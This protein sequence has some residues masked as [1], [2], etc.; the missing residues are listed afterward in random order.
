MKSTWVAAAMIAAGLLSGC[1]DSDTTDASASAVSSTPLKAEGGYIVGKVL[2]QDGK[3]IAVA[4]DI[5]L[6]VYGVSEAG[7]KVSYSPGVKPDGTYKQ[8]LV[9]G[10]YRMGRAIVK[11]KFGE[12]LFNFELT[13]KGNLYNKD[14]D[15]KDGIEQDYVWNMTGQHTTDQPDP[16]NHTHWYG[17]NIGMRFS[18]WRNDINKAPTVPPDGTKLIFTLKPLTKLVNGEDGK[19]LTIEREWQSKAYPQ[20]ADLNDLPPASYEVTGVAKLPDGS[21]KTILLLGK[22]DYPK[23]VPVTKATLELD[24]ILGGMAKPPIGWVVE[25]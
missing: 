13:P 10:S 22:G 16:N 7:E 19:E 9:A 1:G 11:V 12:H 8:K 17:M 14:R 6:S 5:A 18:G 4:E 23:F 24:G 20:S 2:G 25:E 3:P 15:A 21:T